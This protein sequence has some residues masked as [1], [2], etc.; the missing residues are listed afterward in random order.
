MVRAE[1]S[2]AY[3]FDRHILTPVFFA[4]VRKKADLAFTENLVQVEFGC[5]IRGV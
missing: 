3:A 1:I 2:K 4:G 5:Y